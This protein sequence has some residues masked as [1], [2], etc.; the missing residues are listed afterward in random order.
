MAEVHEQDT[1]EFLAQQEAKDDL[2]LDPIPDMPAG[3]LTVQIGDTPPA[4]TQV[5]GVLHGPFGLYPDPDG[6]NPTSEWVVML[7]ATGEK[8][9]THADLAP[10]GMIRQQARRFAVWLSALDWRVSGDGGIPPQTVDLARQLT[11][12]YKL[13]NWIEVKRIVEKIGGRLV[14]KPTGEY[15]TPVENQTPTTLNPVEETRMSTQTAPQPA[16]VNGVQ[17]ETAPKAKRGRRKRD[18]NSKAAITRP[19]VQMKPVANFNANEAE[20]FAQEFG[21]KVPLV[22]AAGIYVLTQ[23][24]IEQQMEALKQAKIKNVENIRAE[25][26]AQGT[27]SESAS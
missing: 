5:E 16:A 17:T 21:E 8:V 9:V 23:L 24:P 1:P 12:A 13:R 26:S 14:D 25:R 19:G 27:T 3:K 20:K 15:T 7:L 6:T 11:H 18:P 22:Y 2:S 4:Y 10:F